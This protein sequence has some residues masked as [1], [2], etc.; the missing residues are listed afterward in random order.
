MLGSGG[1]IDVVT[2][3]YGFQAVAPALYRRALKGGG[4]HLKTSLMEA[5]GAFQSA[6]GPFGPKRA[7]R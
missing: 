1:A 6:F 7:R 4:V 3:L 2:G 5:V